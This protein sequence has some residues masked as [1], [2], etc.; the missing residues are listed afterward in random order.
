MLMLLATS[1]DVMGGYRIR[2]AAVVVGWSAVGAVSL[3][4]LAYLWQQFL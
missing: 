2:G 3:A 4:G 1:Q